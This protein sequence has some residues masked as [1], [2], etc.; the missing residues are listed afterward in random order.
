MTY[1]EAQERDDES[2]RVIQ[3][4]FDA[5]AHYWCGYDNTLESFDNFRKA[6]DR[7]M[8]HAYCDGRQDQR[9][10]MRPAD[11]EDWL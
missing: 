2:E 10:E 9:D 11:F 8:Y 6:I 7:A 1:E 5:A 3:A 4:V